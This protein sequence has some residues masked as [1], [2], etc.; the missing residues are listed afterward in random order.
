MSQQ[1]EY[2]SD[3]QQLDIQMDIFRATF[4]I[5]NYEPLAFD[6][7]KRNDEDIWSC[8]VTICFEISILISQMK[9]FLRLCFMSYDYFE[10]PIFG[11]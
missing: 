11:H 7:V 4:R 3:S 1:P 2:I 9:Y 8:K 10:R 6:W 5:A